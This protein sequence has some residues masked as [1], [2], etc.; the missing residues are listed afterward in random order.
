[1]RISQRLNL[2]FLAIAMWAAVVGHISLYQLNKF[3]DPLSKEIPRSLESIN[4]TAYLEDLAQAMRFYDEVS[5]Q[6]ARNY[7]FTQD[8]RWEQCYKDAKSEYHSIVTEAIDKGT[9]TD[10]RLLSSANEAHLALV[11]M[12]NTS[13][14]FVNNGMAEEAIN[15]LKS[16]RYCDQ[17]RILEQN[18]KDYA[19]KKGAAHDKALANS[20]SIVNLAMKRTQDITEYSRWLVSIFTIIALV[21]ALGSGFIIARS[22]YIP[23][24]K[25]KD[26]T[27]EI[28]KGNLDAQIEI[29][30]GDEIGRVAASF[31]KM[32]DD[33]KRTTTSIDNLGREITERKVA[34]Q[35]AKFACEE[36][37]KA[38]RELKEMQSE[39]VQNAKLVSIGRLAAGVAHELNTPIGFVASNFEALEGYVSKMREL[40]LMFDDL[41]GSIE[42]SEKSELLDKSCV[43]DKTRNSMQIDFIL[44]DIAGLFSDSREG[45]KRVA[46]IV[47]ALRDF[48]RVDQL[49][50]L[51]TYNI[52]DGIKTTLIM[53]RN[54]VKYDID[55]KTEL[56]EV[57]S[58]IC[59][60]GQINQVLLNLIINAAQAIKSQKRTQKG[61]IKIRTYATHED[62][63]CEISD[64]GPGIGS[65][66]LP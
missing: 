34:E 64:N 20:S 17:K 2:G 18:L 45:L 27:V 40:F 55:V 5:T 59:D 10:G 9:K 48:S 50:N 31:K 63:I 41:I 61:I 23:L 43:I 11:E 30:S 7:A 24:Q 46:S 65:N 37:E 58:V 44:E 33:L 39:R 14:E 36:L 32:T 16:S 1:M 26:A 51:D 47:Q 3:S 21:L 56:S 6:S 19:H 49:G 60:A 62:L 35:S 66:D 53:A 42:T 57:P 28:G 25:L 52:N 13:I 54:E 38:N 15:I 8:K 4:K 29:E 12:E 22:I